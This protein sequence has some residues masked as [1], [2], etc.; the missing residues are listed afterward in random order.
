MNVDWRRGLVEFPGVCSALGMNLS[1]Q[2]QGALR[3][4]GADQLVGENAEENHVA[5]D[6]AVA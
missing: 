2:C 3:N 4:S 6:G 5:D 1:G